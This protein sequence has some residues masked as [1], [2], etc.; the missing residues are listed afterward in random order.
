M[1]EGI[2][3]RLFV[4]VENSCRSQ[5]AIQYMREKGIDLM[6]FRDRVEVRVERLID[7]AVRPSDPAKERGR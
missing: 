3:D 7:E 1:S 4:F 5:R 2:P 6:G